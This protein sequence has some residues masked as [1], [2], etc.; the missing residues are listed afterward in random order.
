MDKQ[1]LLVFKDRNE[2]INYKNKLVRITNKYSFVINASTI[3]N[4]H[5]RGNFSTYKRNNKLKQNNH[6]ADKII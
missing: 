2:E 1:Q 5:V 4:S 3:W 6:A